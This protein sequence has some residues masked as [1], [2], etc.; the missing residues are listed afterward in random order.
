MTKHYFFPHRF[1]FSSYF[2]QTYWILVI[3]KCLLHRFPMFSR[4]GYD[5]RQKIRI[6]RRR[7]IHCPK[8]VHT[9]RIVMV[10]KWIK[11]FNYQTLLF[12]KLLYFDQFFFI[13]FAYFNQMLIF[14]F[15]NM[16]WRIL[17]A[18]DDADSFFGYQGIPVLG[19]MDLRS[20]HQR[21]GRAHCQG[22]QLIGMI[23]NGIHSLPYICG[24]HT[25]AVEIDNIWF[26]YRTNEYFVRNFWHW[27]LYRHASQRRSRILSS[28]FINI[29]GINLKLQVLQ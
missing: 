5:F 21:A 17:I 2:F 26:V 25:G 1:Q 12:Q 24:N 23:H 29:I 3:L 18:W 16:F 8:F 19:C 15:S 28:K 20:A 10:I 22:C 27:E 6:K 14:I 9:F 4:R 13:Y 11:I 7:T